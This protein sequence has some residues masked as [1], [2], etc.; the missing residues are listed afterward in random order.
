MPKCP[1]CGFRSRHG[2]YCER[3]GAH[4]D[5]KGHAERNAPANP[6]S[7]SLYPVLIIVI[8]LALI[9]LLL[10]ALVLSGTFKAGVSINATAAATSLTCGGSIDYSVVL[11]GSDG[12]GLPDA[13]V[14]TSVDGFQLERLVTDQNGRLSSSYA[15]PQ[16][17]CGKK[18]N[19]SFV[20]AG[21]YFHKGASSAS[22]FVF[23]IPTAI[24]LALPNMSVNNSVANI[25]VRLVQMRDGKPLAG[26]PVTLTDDASYKATTGPDG[27]ANVSLVFNQTGIKS[28]RA[29]FAGDDLYAGSDIAGQL[30]VMPESCQD[31]TFIGHCANQSIYCDAGKRLVF[32]CSACG[33]GTDLICDNNRCISQEEQTTELISRLQSSVV[34]VENSFASGSGVVISQDPSGTVILTNEHVVEDAYS[35]QDIRIVTNDNRSATAYDVHTAPEGMD[36]AVIYVHG[37]YGEPA[38]INYSTDYEKGDGVLALGSPLGIQGSVSEGII[39]NFLSDSTPIGYGFDEIQTDAA[40][41]HGNSGGGLFMRDSGDLIGINTAILL[42]G[43]GSE[44]Q[45]GFGVAIDIKEL[46]RLAAYTKW[47]EF[48]PIPRCDDGTPYGQCSSNTG[49]FCS[50]TGD[51]HQDCGTCGCPTGLYCPS[52]GVCFSCPSGYTPHQ[53]NDGKGFCCPAGWSVWQDT[54]PFCCP[55]GTVGYVGGTCA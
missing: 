43:S 55:P 22:Y 47:D 33:C 1:R 31:G 51:L 39:S 3:C 20:Y 41:T 32:N 15:V 29:V 25:T 52:S 26:E 13:S 7:S 36:L 4:L 45:S 12:S 38:S 21:D 5:Y 35:V 30:T 50:A 9:G 14:S 37:S 27:T 48:V 40:I 42:S 53:D 49:Y 24:E 17:L 8:C 19:I 11:T 28:I 2:V 6:Y 54:T 46:P 34:Y 44:G 10:G 18:G 23:K 16:D